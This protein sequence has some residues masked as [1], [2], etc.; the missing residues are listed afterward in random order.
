MEELLSREYFNDIYMPFLNAT[1]RYQLFYGGAG[2][3]KSVFI[4]SRIVADCFLGR[5]TLITRQVASR[6]RNSCFNEILKAVR[7]FDLMHC[8]DIKEGLISCKATGAQI[9]FSGLDDADKLKSITP[10]RGVITD[11][12]IEEATETD[13]DSFKQLD[14]RLR[15]VSP[16]KKRMTLSFNPSDKSHWLYENYFKGREILRPVHK[17]ENLIMLHSTY[18]D[19]RFLTEDDV[20]ALENE[21]DAYYRS[22]YTLGLWEDTRGQVLDNV[23]FEDCSGKTFDTKT[24]RCGLD[25]GFSKDPSCAVLLSYDKQNKLIYVIKE[26]VLYSHTNDRLAEKLRIFSPNINI[27][28]DSAEPKSIAELRRLGIRAFPVRK[29]KDARQFSLQWLKQH[30]IVADSGLSTFQ[31]EIAGFRYTDKGDIKANAGDHLID[32]LRYALNSDM[33]YKKA[34]ISN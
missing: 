9:L 23:I 10:E 1:E 28:C 18:K 32:A 4:A 15:G 33:F 27:F 16:H 26:M 24:L 17:S 11:I 21:K 30:T 29:P 31:K 25:F 20:A 3:G 8:F 19:N 13:Y 6:I 7:R 14:K 22:V 5:N 12:W 34:F 2:S